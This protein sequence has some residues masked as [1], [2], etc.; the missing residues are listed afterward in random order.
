[1]PKKM[2]AWRFSSTTGG[3]E[4]NL[5][6]DG[7]APLPKSSSSLHGDPV[8]V[9]VTATAINPVDYKIAEQPFLAPFFIKKPSSPGLDYAGTVVATGS[10]CGDLKPGQPVFG[11]L[12][13][14]QQFGTLG[15]YTVVPKNGAAPLLDGVSIEDAACIGVAGLTAY[16]AIVPYVQKD[17]NV[18]VNGG[19]GGTG[20]FSIQ[21]AKALGCHVSTTCSTLNVKLCQDLG[22]DEVIDYKKSDIV[23]ELE[24]SGRK[25]DLIVDNVGSTPAIYWKGRKYAKPGARYVQ[26]GVEPSGMLDI[27]KRF[28]WPGFLGG[29]GLSYS[30]L[31]VKNDEAQL[32]RIGGWMKEG[33]V[34]AVKDSVF[35]YEDAP[36]AFERL[37][38]GRARGKII[39]NGV[40]NKN[41]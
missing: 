28:L 36:K 40:T 10:N 35:A 12:D 31:M 18:F 22:A 19:S 29:P 11:K 23:A 15:E 3:M 13:T 26:V 41:I 21:I 5:R 8:L 24:K 4:K 20:I 33:K 6:L 27:I 17:A 14:P 25:Y 7:N 2:Q 32:Q 39:I 16:Q 37:K 34:R 30:L 1:M 38:T 9:R